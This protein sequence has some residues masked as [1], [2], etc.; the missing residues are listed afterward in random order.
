[1]YVEMMNV[2]FKQKLNGIGL[3]SLDLINTVHNSKKTINTKA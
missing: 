1:M 3:L 2:H